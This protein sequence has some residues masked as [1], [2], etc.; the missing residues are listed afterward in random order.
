M[1]GYNLLR[2][3]DIAPCKLTLHQVAQQDHS[4]G[5]AGRVYRRP[6][7]RLTGRATS[8]ESKQGVPMGNALKSPRN[9][10]PDGSLRSGTAFQ[11]HPTRAE[12]VAMGKALR[13]KC[14]RSAHAAW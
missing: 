9:E 7:L 3:A 8:A 12:L 2:V 4:G 5:H 10:S 6:G 13:D 1:K 11:T 14:P